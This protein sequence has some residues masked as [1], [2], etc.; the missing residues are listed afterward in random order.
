MEFEIFELSNGIRVVHKQV[1]RTVAHCALMIA[2]GSRDEK[3]G[4]EG[5]AHFIEHVLFKGTKKRK[6]YHILSRME[7]VGGEL[8]AY[9]SKE[10]TVIYTSFLRED[11]ERAI[12]LI[13]DIGLNS[14]FP[15]KE[16][17]KEKEVIIDEINSYRDNPSEAIFDDFEQLIFPENPLG[18]NILGSHESVKAFSRKHVQEFIQR[19]YS[20]EGMVFSSVGNI[21][22]LRLKNK[23]EKHFE[24]FQF[25]PK[26]SSRNKPDAIEGNHRTD[27]KPIVQSHLVM[28]RQTYSANDLNARSL[29]LL[30]N[31][32]G[33]PG[34][35][36]R[37]NLNVREKYGITYNIESFYSPYSDCGL[38]G[39]Y[40]GTDQKFIPK[41]KDLVFKEFKKLR[42]KKLGSLQLAK[43]KRQLLGQIAMGQE[44]NTSLMLALGKSLLAFNK[45]DSFEHISNKINGISAE[46]LQEVSQEVLNPDKMNELLFVPKG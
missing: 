46:H 37:L 45:I 30:N 8:N 41:S 31:L 9:T 43:A 40:L 24:A 5:L 35:N 32:L 27:K 6:A 3:E 18:V 36:S 28:G 21:S 10:E 33:G 4:E 29:M 7:D 39:V 14:S 12:E 25:K 19:E 17:E 2:T 42:D 15:I 22:S 44:N 20:N 38:F 34:M 1:N 13:A 11:Y 26:K 23:L 16:I